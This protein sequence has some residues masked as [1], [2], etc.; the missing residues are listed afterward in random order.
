MYCHKCGAEVLEGAKFC[1]RCGAQT[2]P[3]EIIIPSKEIEK[4]SVIDASYDVKNTDRFGELIGGNHRPWRRFFART[5]DLLTSGIA[6]GSLFIFLLSF[7]LS[8]VYPEG[9]RA[10]IPLFDNQILTGVVMYLAW[11]PVEAFLIST[12]GT[13]P[14]KWIYGI[15][16]LGTSGSKL[17]YS[18]ALRRSCL[19]F[20]QGDGAGLPIVTFFT[21][22]FSYKRLTDTGTT[23]WDTD[24]G[25]VVTHKTWGI[26][27]WI[28]S[29]LS[30]VFA[31]MVIGFLQNMPT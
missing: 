21:R 20:F 30:F 18:S 29:I 11:I 2:V 5:V 26:G 3:K 10:I 9:A 7:V 24:V 6:T 15:S 16:V 31:V 8:M 4:A 14:A 12:T 23:L 27:R 19:V 25:S 22:Y 1:S 28:A 17:S 13:T